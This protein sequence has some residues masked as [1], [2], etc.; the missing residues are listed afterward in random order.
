LF[1]VARMT[2]L[3]YDRRKLLRWALRQA[4]A[5]AIVLSDR[6]PSEVAG[7]IDSSC[8]D[9][10]AIS[11]CKSRLKRWLMLK[12]RSF[13]VGLKRPDL[14][15]KLEAP[16]DMALERDATRQKAGGP[17]AEAVKRRWQLENSSA[18]PQT[19]VV[20]LSTAAALDNTARRAVQAVWA[21]L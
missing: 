9:D 21:A 7:A 4:A 3:A 17:D 11:R 8:F 2:L 1:Y 6:Y 10:V 20:T 13:Y 15:L 5:G 16:L 19:P 14:V 18:F 12:E